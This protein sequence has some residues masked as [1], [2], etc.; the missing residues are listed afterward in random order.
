MCNSNFFLHRRVVGLAF[1]IIGFAIAFA[2]SGCER[3]QSSKPLLRLAVNPT[4]FF[5]PLFVAHDQGF[6]AKRGLESEILM[7][8][9]TGEATNAFLNGDA[10]V[11]ALG[12]GG[13]FFL[14]EKSRGRV[15]LIYVQYNRSYALI[16]PNQSPIAKLED[17]RGKR[18]G[19]WPSPTP[20][21]YLRLI[22]DTR[23]GV[24]NFTAVPIDS[25][26]LHQTMMRGDVDAI[27]AADVHARN[28]IATGQARF[29]SEFPLE[30]YVQKPFFH[31]G[32]LLRAEFIQQ[33]PDTAKAVQEAVSESVA[34]IR[35]NPEQAR[36]S[37][38]RHVRV[39][40]SIAMTTAIDEFVEIDKANFELGQRLADRLTELG[41]LKEKTDV[42]TFRP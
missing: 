26:F 42:N 25:R 20:E 21:I 31:G 23:I 11:S 22:L 15:K 41:I 29:L 16:V 3:R 19:V 38:E 32:G 5:L 7:L 28:S 6:F 14:D 30:E 2:G 18:I 35:T 4:A 37:I 9:S 10:E 33:N 36:E 27:F 13:L 8:T 24:G 17:L 40:R 12:A 1:V 34:F 39:E